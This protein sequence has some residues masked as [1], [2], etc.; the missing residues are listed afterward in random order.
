MDLLA[1]WRCLTESDVARTKFSEWEE[2]R[3]RGPHEWVVKFNEG[4]W[5]KKRGGRHAPEEVRLTEPFDD[6][7]FNF[8]KIKEEEVIGWVDEGGRLFDSR[9]DGDGV[10]AM[11]AFNVSPMFLGHSL[12]IPNPEEKHPQV[13][14]L[15]GLSIAVN[16]I[17]NNTAH[18]DGRIVYNSLGGFATVNHLHFHYLIQRFPVEEHPVAGSIPGSGTFSLVS[19]YPTTVV[20]APLPDSTPDALMSLFGFLINSS[21]PYNALF[22]PSRVYIFPRKNQVE[23]TGKYRMAVAEV[24]GCPIVQSKEEYNGITDEEYS[25][26]MKREID[27]DEAT[28][29]VVEGFLRGV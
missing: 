27:V 2:R 19:G 23:N 21:I 25:E 22:S 16:F 5:A 11:F 13:M 28:W 4:H 29:K 6:E 24:S 15:Q 8:T 10:S 9:P 14:N 18:P 20:T 26:A 7:K 12:I 17:R 1:K 3:V